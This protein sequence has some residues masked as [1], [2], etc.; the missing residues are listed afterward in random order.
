M[1]PTPS[2]SA[3]IARLKKLRALIEHHRYQAHVLDR[4][5]I[6]EAA[7]DSLKHEL[8]TIE[9][10][11]PELITPD[12][13][14]QRVAGHAL[15]QFK[16]VQHLAR[17]FSLSDVFSVAELQDW[18][19][20]WRKLEPRVTTKYLADLKLDGLAVTLTYDHG[21]LSQ[22]ATRGDGYIGEDVT[23]A[24]RTIESVP[25]SLQVEAVSPGVRRAVLAG[26]V[27][28]R[29]EVVMLK[30]DFTAL[31][32]R[33]K[34]AGLPLYANPRN[35]S[36]G[37]IRQLD[38]AVTAARKLNFYAWEL[39][40]DLGQATIS[41]SYDWLKN[42]G[43]KINP[44]ATVCT[45]LE[46]VTRVHQ[47]IERERE[48][49]P[50]W[51]DGLVVKLN[52]LALHRR[53]GFVGKAPRAATA[54]KF[55]AEQ[56]TTVVEDIVVQVGRTGAITPVAHLQPVTVAGT[57]VA[58]ATLHNAEE[59][60]RLDVRV[61]D[62]VI[63]QKAGDIIPDVVKVLPELRPK[64]SKP[65]N[66]VTRC[67]V[68]RTV[69]VRKDGETIVYCPNPKCSA[70]QREGLYHFVTKGAFDIV[71]LG[72]STIDV[73][74]EEG[75]V[76]DAAD[77]FSL[78]TKQLVGLPLF[79]EKK[80]ENLVAAIQS[81][82]SIPLDRFLYGLGIRHVGAETARAV[83]GTFG[84]LEKILRA[85]AEE[86]SATPDVGPVVAASIAGFFQS[87]TNRRLVDR[88]QR[89]VKIIT[90]KKT[91]GGSLTG[92]TIV[93]TGTLESMS[94]GEAEEAI[95]Q[96]GG[97]QASTVSKKTAAVVVGADPGSKADKAQSLGVAIWDEARFRRELGR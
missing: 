46:D 11:Y 39:V 25:L 70:K 29:G 44:R 75:L 91:R 84:S 20:R 94:R 48:S 76:H 21:Q 41:Q 2:K 63:I 53:L 93:V 69:V 56:A 72:P 85:S 77:I 60:A 18:D 17:M 86:L 13:P 97:H 14:S 40:T 24:V 28:V 15:P 38:P 19:Q 65:W 12:S 27:E 42:F 90:P 89:H 23:H 54:W 55:S 7:L 52:D 67:P 36:A 57:T 26:I 51:I 1:K 88:L 37:S 16:K 62:T 50:F 66:M 73:L 80:A 30:K 95:R 87:T 79:A 78:A 58:R 92:E 81:R 10:Q 4:Q 68:C 31:N 5:E 74:I 49:L 43:L 61:G 71:G 59:I 32:E 64:T 33:Q 22:A 83:A 45:S 34:R 96:A 35:V 8:A 47:Q 9:A 82:Q 6:S 3:A